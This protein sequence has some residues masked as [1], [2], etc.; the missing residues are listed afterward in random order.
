MPRVDELSLTTVRTLTNTTAANALSLSGIVSS[1]VKL[2]GNV[3]H[4][5]I[6]ELA[7]VVFHGYNLDS[8]TLTSLTFEAYEVVND[9][10]D[11]ETAVYI[12]QITLVAAD[13]AKNPSWIIPLYAQKLW[14]RLATVTGSSAQFDLTVSA[15]AC[16]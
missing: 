12:D 2:P 10:A 14:V 1:A 9:S 6:P 11:V 8:G 5:R 13:L 3:D 15:R 16:N 4:H 7:Q